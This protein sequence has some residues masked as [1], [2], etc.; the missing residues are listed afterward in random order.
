MER[1]QLGFD[2]GGTYIKAGVINDN[3]EIL[4]KRSVPFPH[5]GDYKKVVDILEQLTYDME[6]ELEGFIGQFKSIGVAV[7][8]DIDPTGSIVINAHNLGFHN[9][10]LRQ[11]MQ[12]RFPE[13]PVL[14]GNDANITALA[15]LHAGALRGCQTGVLLTLGT[16]VGGGIILDG[17]MFNGG[18][19]HGV[20]LGHMIM[21][22]GGENCTCGNKG[23]V[24]SVCTAT[25]LI[26]QGKAVLSEGKDSLICIKAKND[27]EKVHAK[28]IM[29]SAKEGDPI[30]KEI[31][32][33]YVS[34]LSSAIVTIVAVLDPEIIAIGGGVSLTGDFLFEPLRKIVREKAFFKYDYKI[35]PAQLGNDAGIIGAALLA[36]N[37]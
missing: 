19:K 17:K 24:E 2:I 35:V 15:E 1:F 33:K 23:C 16:G 11:E 20:E 3:M 36:K 12:D 14:I 9:V 4:A 32:D 28:M 18:L 10:P 37:R 31:F 7:A 21:M 25:W 29:D 30:A 6:N 27:P 26:A 13:I 8:G 34:Y 22:H 5:E